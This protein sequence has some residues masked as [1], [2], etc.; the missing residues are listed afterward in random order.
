MLAAG[1]AN[2]LD[3]P[4]RVGQGCALHDGF[5]EQVPRLHQP[6]LHAGPRALDDLI[7]RD[8]D[9]VEAGDVV[10][11]VLTLSNGA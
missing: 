10:P 5:L 11:V 4:G 2:G 7:D 6:I 9:G 8:G 3:V 1:A